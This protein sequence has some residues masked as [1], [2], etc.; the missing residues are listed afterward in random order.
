MNRK[1]LV[2]QHAEWAGPGRL[3]LDAVH[4]C[5]TRLQVVRM[6]KQAAPDP[7]DFDALILLGGPVDASDRTLLSLLR[8]ERRL[9]QAWLS[10]DR[11]CLGFN[12]G[13]LLLAE[14]FKAT[15]GSNFIPDIGFTE[16][17][18]THHGR[19]HPVFHNIATPMLL[20]KWHDQ[21]IQ[22]PVPADMIP[23]ATSSHCV[24]EAFSI[25]GRPSIIGLQCDN[26]AAHP[27]DVCR[28]ITGC[29]SSFPQAA[30]DPAWSEQLARAA[31][32][33][34]AE[35]RQTFTKLVKNFINL[36]EWTPCRETMT[37]DTDTPLS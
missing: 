23:L 35:T 5:R 27:E 34:L 24:V 4:E 30:S 37:P 11:P 22:T 25:K 20:F 18:L 21:A 10:L 16:G 15:V 33:H 9:L 31:D 12:L 14:A 8:E 36:S 32:R 2:V 6:W 19:N 26:Y 7:A 17:H 13:H 3:L 28:W 1:I 29:R